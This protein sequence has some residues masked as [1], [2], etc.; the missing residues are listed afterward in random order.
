MCCRTPGNLFTTPSS[1]GV[2]QPSV[3]FLG[4]ILGPPLVRHCF[5]AALGPYQKARARR[6]AQER[7]AENI[8]R[9]SLIGDLRV[10]QHCVKCVSS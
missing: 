3:S 4:A 9:L 5:V 8:S 6:G 10:P 2:Q 7:G 1:L